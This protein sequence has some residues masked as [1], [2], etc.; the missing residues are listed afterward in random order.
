MTLWFFV[1]HTKTSPPLR[2]FVLCFSG[3]ISRTQLPRFVQH[4]LAIASIKILPIFFSS[5]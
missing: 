2:D 1:F 5:F 3:L 4:R